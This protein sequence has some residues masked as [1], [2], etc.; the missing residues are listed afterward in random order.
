[1]EMKNLENNFW[2]RF[3]GRNWQKQLENFGTLNNSFI[4]K[5]FKLTFFT[6]RRVPGVRS[7]KLL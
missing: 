2:K 5:L 7:G 3:P 1:M 4:E 6:S